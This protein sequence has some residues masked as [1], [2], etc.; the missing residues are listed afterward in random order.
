MARAVDSPPNAISFNLLFSP[1][2]WGFVVRK[3]FLILSTNMEHGEYKVSLSKEQVSELVKQ[4][5]ISPK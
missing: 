5:F 1:Q 4:K 3:P 2:D